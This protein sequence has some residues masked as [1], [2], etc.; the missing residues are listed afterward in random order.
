M[1]DEN[2]ENVFQKR[3][4]F[5]VI[6]KICSRCTHFAYQVIFQVQDL[7]YFTLPSHHQYES[8][9]WHRE[10]SEYSSGRTHEAGAGAQAL[11]CL[12][13]TQKLFP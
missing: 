5:L 10:P 12:S 4:Y 6:S 11:H 1:L 9:S 2:V 7:F 3:C 13:E 8:C